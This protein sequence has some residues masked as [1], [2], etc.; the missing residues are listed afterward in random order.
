MADKKVACYV[1]KG[2]GLGDRLDTDN[3][4]LIAE[5][6]AKAQHVRDHDFLCSAAGVRMIQDDIAN[7]GV[8]H[9]CIAA[10]SRRVKTEAF[11]FP[12]IAIARASLRE[13]VIWARPDDAACRETTQEMAADLVRM[14]LDGIGTPH[15]D[16]LL[17]L[18]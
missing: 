10:C 6:E 14:G 5:R 12:D 9:A 17:P 11:H 7:A 8:T 16:R 4:K 13:G 3:L 2:C 15:P 18:L 1:C